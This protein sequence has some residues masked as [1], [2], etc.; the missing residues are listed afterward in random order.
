M[1]DTAADQARVTLRERLF[2]V[3]AELE[4]QADQATLLVQSIITERERTADALGAAAAQRTT[5]R[6]LLRS[7]GRTGGAVWMIEGTE[8]SPLIVPALNEILQGAAPEGPLRR[9]DER[10][11]KARCQAADVA[12]ATFQI[13][14]LLAK[15]PTPPA[16]SLH[17]DQEKETIHAQ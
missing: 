5:L 17:P 14:L 10:L 2:V 3:R 1:S 15:L 11:R 8:I 7:E 6:E 13:G 9:I 12:E 4:H 16:I